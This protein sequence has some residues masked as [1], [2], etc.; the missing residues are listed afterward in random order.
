MKTI[1]PWLTLI[2]LFPFLLLGGLLFTA[3]CA[4]AGTSE[5]IP[6]NLLPRRRKSLATYKCYPESPK[7][8]SERLTIITDAE[9]EKMRCSAYERLLP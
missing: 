6:V 9:I 5:R 7:N 2:V 8:G 3:I 4:F 1:K